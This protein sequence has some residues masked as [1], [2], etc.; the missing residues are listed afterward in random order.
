MDKP[1]HAVDSNKKLV[2]DYALELGFDLVGIASA[3]PFAEHRAITLQRIREGLMDGLP[4]FTE[5]RVSIGG[6][7]PRSFCP[8][9]A[10]SSPWG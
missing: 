5:A 4:W 8:V 1:I 9:P 2:K 10:P 7:A 6:P 3:E